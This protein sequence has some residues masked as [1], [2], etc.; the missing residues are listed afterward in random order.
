M[1]PRDARFLLDFFLPQLKFEQTRTRAV[2][3]AVP[4]DKGEY[5]PAPQSRSA[6]ELAWH[7]VATEMW[8]LDAVLNRVFSE[9]DGP[10]A[11]DPKTVAE[12]VS[13][14]DRYFSARLPRLE[15][16]SGEHLAVPVDYVGVRN[17][18]AVAYLSLT[19]PHTAHHRG[20]L[21]AYLRP[22]GAKVPVIYL[23]SADGSLLSIA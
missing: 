1:Q 4:P 10:S 14:Y 22:M 3:L 2:L 9:D 11:D 20:Q 16:L 18:P 21:S 19:L 8:F 15:S 5:R 17:D 12:V 6:F 13:W 7:I 23:E